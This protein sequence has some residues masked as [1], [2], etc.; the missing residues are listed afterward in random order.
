V[1]PFVGTWFCAAAEY[2]LPGDGGTDFVPGVVVLFAA[3]GDGTLLQTLETPDDGSDGGDFHRCSLACVVSGSVT[4]A[5][6]AQSCSLWEDGVA[7]G[8]LMS[9]TF[10]SSG[11]TAIQSVTFAVRLSDGGAEPAVYSSSCTRK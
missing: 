10:S 3:T 7:V 5:I 6:G 9:E 8:V 2:Y 1:S 11:D 4:A